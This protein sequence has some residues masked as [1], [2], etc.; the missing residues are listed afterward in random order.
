MEGLGEGMRRRMWLLLACET[1]ASA[2]ELGVARQCCLKVHLKVHL[3]CNLWDP[4]GCIITAFKQSSVFLDPQQ[5]MFAKHK[6]KNNSPNVWA[7]ALSRLHM[8]FLF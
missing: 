6:L 2:A 1:C 3:T 5:P 7:L 8:T 4:P